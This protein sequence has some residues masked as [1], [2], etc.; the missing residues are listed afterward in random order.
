MKRVY[1]PLAY[2]PEPIRN[3]FWQTTTA[4]L[5]RPQ[6]KGAHHTDVAIIGGGFTGLNA[7]LHLAEDG[8]D[9][10]LLDA[11]RIA[12]G[13]S[14]RNG[15]FC[16]LGGGTIDDK[17]LDKRYGPDGRR[18]WHRAEKDAIGHVADLLKRLKIDADTHSKGETLLAHKASRMALLQDHA[19][20]IQENYGVD[21]ILLSKDDLQEQGLNGPFH[22][23]LTTPIGFALN[24]L[25]Y[26]LGIARAALTA[27]ATRPL[28]EQE[29]QDAGWTS[30]QMAYDSRNL[31]H[32]FRLMPD[33]RFLFGMRGGIFATRRS[34]AKIKALIRAD[35]ERMFPA[36]AH[37]E[38][39]HMWSGLVCMNVKGAPF[40]GPI[41]N[42]DGAFTSLSYHGNGVAMASYCGMLLAD[43]VQDETPRAP[44]P[45]VLQTPPSKIP[46]GRK[47]RWFLPPLYKLMEFSDR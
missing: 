3:G 46:L 42:M 20:S 41:P 28:N 17:Q 14:G 16:C 2:G 43:L 23:A 31:L 15:G 38:T 6:L 45:S 35:F 9:V 39:P 24:P 33:R 30:E 18:A 25:K 5:E 19:A 4:P 29:L 21:P 36:W 37:V 22:G 44:Y 27:G 1:E 7:A 11:Q 40:T 10:T 26:A 32:Y 47:R 12:W 34:D 8:V 13:A